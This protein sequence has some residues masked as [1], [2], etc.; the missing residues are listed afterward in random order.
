MNEN[1]IHF[2]PDGG[3]DEGAGKTNYVANPL[4]LRRELHGNALTKGLVGFDEFAGEV[5]LLRPIPRP[6]LKTP[7]AFA[8]RPWADADDTALAEHFN[9]RG[10]K[11]IG[12]NLVRDVIELEARSQPFHPLR[13]RLEGLSWDGTKRLSRFF[14]DYCGAV[15][16]GD[17]DKE[18]ADVISYIEA[19]TRCFFISAVARALR[20]GVKADCALILEG[21]QGALKSSLLRML[22]LNDEWFS[23]SLPHD[24]ESKDAR[25]HLAGRWIVEL[26]EIAQFRRSEIETVKSFLSCQSD[27]YRPSYGR[28]VVTVPRQCIFCG[29]TNAETY[30]VDTTGNRRFWPIRIEAVDLVGVAKIV[31]QLWA[32]AVAA[33]RDGEIWWLTPKIERIAAGQT[34]SRIDTDP[35]HDKIDEYVC[36]RMAGMWFT[37]ADVLGQLNVD[38]SRRDRAAEMRVG[39]VL[40]RLKCARKKQRGGPD[41]KPRW[42]YSRP[43]A[44]DVIE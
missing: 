42:A 15:V 31:D 10:F 12:R 1:V 2:Q 21:K 25:Q 4:N 7:K 14:L 19:V 9:Q 18:R 39:A 43:A 30:L 37:T 20:P 41:N 6:H 13:E 23:D 36:T 32:E 26:G 22:A 33:W 28:S 5:M 29:T 8:P 34:D 24:L 38:M 16:D 35:W 44:D 3:G 27:K 40:R 17:D 11:R